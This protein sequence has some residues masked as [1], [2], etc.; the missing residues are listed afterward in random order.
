[1]RL[2]PGSEGGCGPA[3][4]NN[5]INF[6]SLTSSSPAVD[7][8]KILQISDVGEDQRDLH[9]LLATSFAKCVGQAMSSQLPQPNHDF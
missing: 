4:A 7:T 1:M 2:F 3:A 5:V 9:A 6:G 8:F